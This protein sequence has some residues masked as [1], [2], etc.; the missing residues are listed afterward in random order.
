M[1]THFRKDSSNSITGPNPDGPDDLVAHITKHRGMK[2]A[3][4]S[5]SADKNAIKHFSGVLYRTESDHIMRDDHIFISHPQL[6]EELRQ[7]IQTSRRAERIIAS[8]ALQLAARAKEALIHWQF[9]L[10]RMDRKERMGW[11]YKQIQ[12]YFQRA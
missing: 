3:F 12:K 7:K 4:T 11:C 10:D 5:V 6:I 1:A 8:R 2:T 9:D